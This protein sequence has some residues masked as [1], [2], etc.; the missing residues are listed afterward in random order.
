[1]SYD[2]SQLDNYAKLSFYSVVGYCTLDT[3][4]DT[5]RSHMLW[6]RPRSRSRQASPLHAI[7]PLSRAR[8]PRPLSHKSTLVSVVSNTDSSTKTVKLAV[9]RE[10]SS[11]PTSVFI[12]NVWARSSA[13]SCKWTEG[14]RSSFAHAY[15]VKRTL[16]VCAEQTLCVRGGGLS[17]FVGS[18]SVRWQAVIRS[19]E[20]ISMLRRRPGMTLYEYAS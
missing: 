20:G 8:S 3:E 2:R 16:N 11:K 5:H 15:G 9:Y 7:Q 18:T 10:T 1:V 12:L 13:S 14:A 19:L 6:R 4:N 17:Y